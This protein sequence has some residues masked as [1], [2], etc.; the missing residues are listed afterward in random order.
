MT[1]SFKVLKKKRS[2]ISLPNESTVR[3]FKQKL[4]TFYTSRTMLKGTVK[5]LNE[6]G[7]LYQM[8]AQRCEKG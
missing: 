8:E 5:Q 6:T 3:H 4:I 2:A 1:E 7:K